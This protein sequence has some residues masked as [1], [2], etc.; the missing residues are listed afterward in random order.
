MWSFRPWVCF[1]V[2]HFVR[3]YS[4]PPSTPG[5]SC[6]SFQAIQPHEKP[7]NKP[8]ATR[9]VASSIARG[10]EVRRCHGSPVAPINAPRRGA[11]SALWRG[12]ADVVAPLRG[13]LSGCGFTVGSVVPPRPRLFMFGLSDRR[14][15]VWLLV[16]SWGIVLRP[17]P[18]RLLMCGLSGNPTA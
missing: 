17:H 6:V 18:P 2:A 14:L 1:V 10:E 8:R 3:G 16:L 9:R 15:A 5:C 13:A 7:Y 11:T 4:V 12:H